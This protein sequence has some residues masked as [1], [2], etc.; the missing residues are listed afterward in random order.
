MTKLA[1]ILILALSTVLPFSFW[2]AYRQPL[3]IS[4][5]LPPY[6]SRSAHGSPVTQLHNSIA[7]SALKN[8][9]YNRVSRVVVV[10]DTAQGRGI[11][12]DG[13]CAVTSDPTSSQRYLAPVHDSLW[14]MAQMYTFMDRGP[15]IRY[16][17]KTINTAG[18]EWYSYSVE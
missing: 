3:E 11:S 7:G 18:A 16:R 5:D 4:Y 1:C 2:Q 8:I 14:L 13:I 15:T 12:W 6:Q 9:W 17:F 10:P